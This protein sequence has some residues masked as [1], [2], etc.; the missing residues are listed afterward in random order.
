[1]LCLH[2]EGGKMAPPHP[3]HKKATLAYIYL[4]LDLMID[5]FAHEYRKTS[6]GGVA[7]LSEAGSSMCAAEVEMTHNTHAGTRALGKQHCRRMHVRY[8]ICLSQR[9]KFTA[10]F[11]EGNV[12]V[13]SSH[14]YTLICMPAG[15][16][17]K[18]R[19]RRLRIHAVYTSTYIP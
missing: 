7:T 10:K 6:E 18:N 8:L 17:R 15:E 13:H 2:S 9:R 4:M 1:M 5:I 19:T 12:N 3:Q 14:F 11:S 16:Y